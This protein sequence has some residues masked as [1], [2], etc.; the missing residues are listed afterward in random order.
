MNTT[1]IP[2]YCIN[3]KHRKDRK[4]HSLQQFTKLNILHDAVI[5]LPFTKDDRGG[6]YGCFD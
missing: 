6:V 1:T 5:Y 2:I 3:L 4:E